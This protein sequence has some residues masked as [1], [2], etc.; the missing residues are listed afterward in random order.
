MFHD[1]RIHMGLLSC[2]LQKTNFFLLFFD[3][4]QYTAHT[5]MI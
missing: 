5:L 4:M 3:N 1:L 2:V